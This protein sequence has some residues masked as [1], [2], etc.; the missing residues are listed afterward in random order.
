MFLDRINRRIGKAAAWLVP[1]M[2]AIGAFNAVARYLG[3]TIRI[4]LSSNAFIEL[5]WYL[6]SAVFLLG[7]A[8]T[9]QRDRHVRVDV[10][11]GRL[12]R[13]RR[14]AID[15]SGSL[16]LALPFCLVMVW[17]SWP[18]VV[19]SWRV[20]EGSPD[21]GGLPRYPLRTLVPIA[22]GLLALQVTAILLRRGRFA[23]V[24]H[25]PSGMGDRPEPDVGRRSGDLPGAA[26]NEAATAP[27]GSGVDEGD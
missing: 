21:P 17:I 1:A 16:V 20:F 27:G 10:I 18:S 25:I 12:R 15:F 7:A 4:D 22:F 11:Y 23:P 26:G 14:Q 3:R 8:Y 24:D 5:Q 6:F 13:S 9:L 19:N 2:I